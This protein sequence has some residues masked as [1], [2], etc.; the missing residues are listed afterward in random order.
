[1][2]LLLVLLGLLLTA[3]F[4]YHCISS[5]SPEI[6]DDIGTRVV[7]EMNAGGGAFDGVKVDVSGRDVLLSG[8]VASQ[9]IKDMAGKNARSLYGVRVVDNQLNVIQPIPE[10][11]PIPEPIVEAIPE[12]VIEPEPEPVAVDVC[13]DELAAIVEGE[14]INFDSG[15]D[16]IKSESIAVID[17]I[18]VAAKD[19]SDAVIHVHGHTDS[20]GN[21]SFNK[22]L[23]VR[24]ASSVAAYLASNGVRQKLRATGHGSASPIASND[25]AEGRAQNRRIEFK[26]YKLEEN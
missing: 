20:S 6:Q 5:H 14:Q 9:D 10:P 4:F 2:R 17:R 12:P 1:M 15:K 23:S 8:D 7:A 18:V 11:E 13:Q 19:C 16:T 22:D 3:Y 21:A 25:N 26:V 24:R